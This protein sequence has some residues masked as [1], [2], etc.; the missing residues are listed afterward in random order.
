MARRRLGDLPFLLL[1][2]IFSEFCYELAHRISADLVTY[3]GQL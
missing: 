1:S 3:Q 2:K